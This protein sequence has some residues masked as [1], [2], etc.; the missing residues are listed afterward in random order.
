[1]S[2]LMCRTNPSPY[3]YILYADAECQTDL[4]MDDIKRMEDIRK[5][6]QFSQEPFQKNEDLTKLY[7]G[8]PKFFVL[9][10]VFNAAV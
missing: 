4:T 2:L 6:T 1:M 9:M 7:T 10:P 3:C 5:Q 8:L